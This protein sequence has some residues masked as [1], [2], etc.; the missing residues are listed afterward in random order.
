MSKSCKE[1]AKSWHRLD[2]DDLKVLRLVL[3]DIRTIRTSPEL[4]GY[5]MAFHDSLM[6]HRE[7]FKTIRDTAHFPWQQAPN[8]LLHQYYLGGLLLKRCCIQTEKLSE[9]ADLLFMAIVG[10]MAARLLAPSADPEMN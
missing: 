5:L 3:N 9:W 2:N 7:E 4:T 1:F 6:D 10:E 8:G